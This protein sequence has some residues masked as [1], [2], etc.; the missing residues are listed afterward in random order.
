MRERQAERG[1]ERQREEKNVTECERERQADIEPI[2]Q[3]YF[4][5]TF[6][7]KEAT[8]ATRPRVVCDSRLA[9]VF[10]VK[11]RWVSPGT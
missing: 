2:V 8:I 6:F 5:Y 11:S 10:S 4:K 9:V 1:N 3:E 7:T